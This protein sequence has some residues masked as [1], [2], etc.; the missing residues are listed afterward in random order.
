M[1]KIAFYLKGYI[2]ECILAP[3]FKLLEATNELIVPFIMASII[4]VGIDGGDT[5]YVIKMGLLLALLALTGFAF[6]CAAQF[7]AAKAAIGFS[8]ELRSD[9][10]KHIQSLSFNDLN[11]FGTSKLI[12]IMTGDVNQAQTG[13]NQ[14]LR[15]LLRSPFVV[16][17]AMAAAFMIDANVAFI[18]L[19]VIIILCLVVFGI[20]LTCIPMH[21]DVQ[22][23]LDSV[24]AKVRENLNGVR[25][26]RA[27]AGESAEVDEFDNKN[28]RL[29]K[30]Q[31]KVGKISSLLNPATLL[32]VN[33]AIIALL[34]TG[35]IRVNIGTLTQGEVTALYNLMSQI[36]IEL[37]KM[38]NLIITATKSAA[39]AKRCAQVLS[40]SST[41]NTGS[42]LPTADA[43]NGRVE[44]TDV[45]FTF[46]DGREPAISHISF[47]ANPGETIGIIGG[48]GSGK[49]SLINLIP[50][51]Y[52][53]TAGTVKVDDVNVNEFDRTSLIERI[54][55][56]P[57]HALLFEGTI[58]SNLL[59]GNKQAS[60]DELLNALSI[61]QALEIINDKP[62]GLDT[63]VEQGGRNFSGGQKQRL[64]IAR[65]L[66]K[67]PEILIMDDSASALDYATDAKLRKSIRG[68]ENPPTTFII[69]Q[70][71][72][73][74]LHADKIIVMDDGRIVSIGT[75][76][77]LMDTCD[78]YKEIYNSQFD[79]SG[80]RQ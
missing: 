20:I 16:F 47:C 29:T 52:N 38:A 55:L 39:C 28:H 9:L 73:S 23:N 35:A 68:M 13:V 5:N 19:F 58:R 80:G 11:H 50:G 59:M 37:V 2:K 36:L 45:S 30:L 79:N 61:A 53:A 1:K 72:A 42:V 71:T 8:E 14:L 33:I 21:T 44:F 66:V 17:G 25:V 67:K 27:F 65:A 10:L 77:E 74:V 70:R 15:L 62:Y 22:Q 51:F 4:D 41:Q 31:L 6:A 40:Y 69:S 63:H 75:H 18:F 49:T 3:L 24:T 56:V 32:I 57:Q 64:T 60:D 34:W 26:I 54:G 78:V 7:F 76:N 12:T 48:T 46:P 43:P